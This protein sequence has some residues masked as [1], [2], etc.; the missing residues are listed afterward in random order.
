MID[1]LMN[2]LGLK[3]NNKE[4]GYYIQPSNENTFFEDRQAYL[5]V[6]QHK[7]GVRI[8]FNSYSYLELFIQRY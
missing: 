4:L 5:Y 7:A 1:A 6:K 8:L 2:K 3:C